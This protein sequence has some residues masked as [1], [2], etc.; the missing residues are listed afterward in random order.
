[1]FNEAL[2]WDAPMSTSLV[3]APESPNLPSSLRTPGDRKVALWPTACPRSRGFSA[4]AAHENSRGCAHTLRTAEDERRCR[5]SRPSAD[6][7]ICV[8]PFTGLRPAGCDG[9]GTP[10]APG[11]GTALEEPVCR[12]RGIAGRGPAAPEGA[13]REMPN[14]LRG[15]GELGLAMGAELWR[16]SRSTRRAARRMPC[17]RDGRLH[18]RR[19]GKPREGLGR[20]HG[21]LPAGSWVDASRMWT[22]RFLCGEV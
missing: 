18:R 21:S 4:D 5:L 13:G 19:G 8:R 10:L 17:R 20:L 22:S 2:T 7:F 12:A 3:P 16:E 1:M 15:A 14:S 6:T 9:A 11:A